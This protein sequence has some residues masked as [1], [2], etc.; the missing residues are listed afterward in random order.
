MARS[1]W[2]PAGITGIS[3]PG[4]LRLDPQREGGPGGLGGGRSKV[5]ADMTVT[6]TITVALA[7]PEPVRLGGTRRLTR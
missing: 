1:L 4:R 6:V 3:W 5:P 2:Q 7:Q